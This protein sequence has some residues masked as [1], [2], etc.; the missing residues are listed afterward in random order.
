[1]EHPRLSSLVPRQDLALVPK[2][3]L[4]LTSTILR[5]PR[6]TQGLSKRVESSKRDL[7]PRPKARISCGKRPFIRLRTLM[8][9][10][11]PTLTLRR[12]NFRA[13]GLVMVCR[14]Q[15]HPPLSAKASHIHYSPLRTTD[16]LKCYWR[17]LRR[18]PKIRTRPRRNSKMAID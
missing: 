12:S 16:Q 10:P 15:P 5:P 7:T 14:P 1:M 11:T 18:V 9:A 2:R 17:S 3:I 13:V 8:L 6:K 4:W